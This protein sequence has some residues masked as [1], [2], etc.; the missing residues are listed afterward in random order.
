MRI[1]LNENLVA[2]QLES[3][4]ELE[5]LC[6]ELGQQLATLNVHSLDLQQK[7]S[8][9][10]SSD[11]AA[12]LS[13]EI[14]II[15]ALIDSLKAYSVEMKCKKTLGMNRNKMSQADISVLEAQVVGMKKV[16]AILKGSDAQCPLSE[17][18]DSVGKMEY[19][20]SYARIWARR[21]ANILGSAVAVAAAV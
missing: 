3:Q 2:S 15:N 4:A 5:R 20:L 18:I 17:S 6:V 12:D 11:T 10:V 8:L 13:H 9:E 19:Q 1:S 16:C 21:V 14:E 7:L